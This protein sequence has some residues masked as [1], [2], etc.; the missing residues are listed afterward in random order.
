MIEL[1][2]LNGEPILIN[3]RQIEYI[4][5]IPESKIIMM[6]GKYHIVREDKDEI[7]KK[8]I[9]FNNQCIHYPRNEEA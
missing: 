1:T 8:V 6:N 3:S 5:L 9:I 4:E 2:K 7:I